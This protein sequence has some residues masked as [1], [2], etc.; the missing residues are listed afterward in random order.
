MS[1]SFALTPPQHNCNFGPKAVL[2]YAGHILTPLLLA[3]IALLLFSLGLKL[4]FYFSDLYLNVSSSL[5][6]GIY[7]SEERDEPLH[8]DELVL[9]CLSEEA[10]KLALSR[11]YL[12]AH[13]LFNRCPP[14]GKYVV[15]T[16][17]DEV[18]LE[19]EGI[20]VNNRLLPNTAPLPCDGEGRELNS[21]PFNTSLKE[22]ELLLASF[23]EASYDS[24]YFG[25][26]K[27]EQ[28]LGRLK[29]VFT[30]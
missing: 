15:A 7:E 13:G 5:P 1:S 20:R 17:G 29:P 24:R 22:H 26:V 10:A 12:S 18:K 3:V 11:G 19:K 2:G 8:K 25:V 23:M 9:A 16:A 21:V 4:T 30:F 6:L 27:E 28:I 14:I